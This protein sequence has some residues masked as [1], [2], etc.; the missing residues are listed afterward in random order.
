MT[1]SVKEV[2]T[3][4]VKEVMTKKGEGISPL[5]WAWHQQAVH[6]SGLKPGWASI[7]CVEL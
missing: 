5:A 4:R 6:H 1:K 7:S 3:K 2:M